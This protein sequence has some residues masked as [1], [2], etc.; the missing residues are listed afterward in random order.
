[1]KRYLRNLGFF[2]L[3][4]FPLGIAMMTVLQ[5]QLLLPSAAGVGLLVVGKTQH[6][7]AVMDEAT[8][9]WGCILFCTSYLLWLNRPYAC[10][11][12]EASSRGMLSAFRHSSD[13]ASQRTPVSWHA[14]SHFLLCALMA[15]P[16]FIYYIAYITL[17]DN[18]LSVI[19]LN[20][21]LLENG[22]YSIK[23]NAWLI[24]AQ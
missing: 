20:Y 12:L 8:R 7:R 4:P 11:C 2:S 3:C 1:L 9:C 23:S 19:P 24:S 13:T 10:I 14:A 6:A 16:A 17:Y 18:Y 21:K 22:N 15:L 5:N